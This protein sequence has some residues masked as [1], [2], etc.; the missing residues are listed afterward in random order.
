M[1]I[2]HQTDHNNSLLT[3]SGGFW[4]SK[5]HQLQ[6]PNFTHSLAAV[7][8][9]WR[10]T[11]GKMVAWILVL[12]AVRKCRFL[13][14]C[15]RAQSD[16]TNQK[17]HQHQ[18]WSVLY[19]TED[20]FTTTNQT[21]L[22]L[23]LLILKRFKELLPSWLLPRCLALVLEVEIHQR[24]GYLLLL[25]SLCPAWAF[26]DL[27]FSRLWETLPQA[28][29]K[30]AKTVWRRMGQQGCRLYLCSGETLKDK[31]NPLK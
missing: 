26:E 29:G 14:Y 8:L 31:K 21:S 2:T 15:N 17:H 18:H 5:R 28:L 10:L 20:S 11:T 24:R 4:F 13:V 1:S 23:P 16:P 19:L 30:T 27:T 3:S 22:N 6:W 25:R 12:T 9:L 7:P